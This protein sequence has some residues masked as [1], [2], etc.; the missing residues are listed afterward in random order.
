VIQGI[1]DQLRGARSNPPAA[2]PSSPL[3]DN[4]Y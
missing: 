2:E 1:D 4:P 3:Q